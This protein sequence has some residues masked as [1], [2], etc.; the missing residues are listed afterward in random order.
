MRLL[1]TAVTFITFTACCSNTPPGPPPGTPP[2]PK[3][4]P[5]SDLSDYDSSKTECGACYKT[6]ENS[7]EIYTNAKYTGCVN[8]FNQPEGEGELILEETQISKGCFKNGELDGY[9]MLKTDGQTYV[10]SWNNG[11]RDGYGVQTTEDQTYEGNWKNG[12]R[13]GYGVQKIGEQIY[14]GEWVNDRE[15]GQGTLTI[16]SSTWIGIFNDGVKTDEGHYIH[17]NYYNPA[18]II[19]DS[20]VI[21]VSLEKHPTNPHCYLDVTFGD[22]TGTFMFDTGAS[23]ILVDDKFISELRETNVEVT[24][25]YHTGFSTIANNETIE[26]EFYLIEKFTIGEL[27]VENVVVSS[28][29]NCSKLLGIGFL[30][31]FSNHTYSGDICEL[32]LVK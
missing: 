28:C 4:V 26:T 8:K 29:E 2:V 23:G 12:R 24:K 25:L 16:D 19:H 22:V 17:D 11:L 9:G 20:D 13:E 1:F 3:A 15:H 14:E 32:T 5:Q 10:G 7:S 31:K 6:V 30:S 18:D 21:T 27:I